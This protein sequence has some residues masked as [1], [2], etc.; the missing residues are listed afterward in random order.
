MA[1]PCLNPPEQP[2]IQPLRYRRPE[3]RT[4]PNVG[5]YLI[6]IVIIVITMI[7]III[8]TIVI[9]IIRIGSVQ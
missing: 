2:E 5:G 7:I 4:T 8:I 9:I 6:I 1:A 3:D